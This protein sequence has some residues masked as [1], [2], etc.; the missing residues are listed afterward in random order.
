[1]TIQE[2]ISYLHTKFPLFD[3]MVIHDTD[4]RGNDFCETIM[5]NKSNPNTPL[6]VCVTD[7]GCSISVG[8]FDNV[9]GSSSMTVEQACSAIRDILDDKI[10]FVIGYR[11]GDD[12]GFG[13]PFFSRVFA[14][15]GK[16]D[17]MSEDYERFLKRI[18][19]PLGKFARVFSPMKGRFVIFNFS[20]TVN[21]EILR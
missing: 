9:T 11:G 2:Q 1:V 18:S 21:K 20:G 6:T 13:T 14:L 10:L 3:R 4:N 7:R 8:Q 16:N 5:P 15:T 12:T 17:D 19:S